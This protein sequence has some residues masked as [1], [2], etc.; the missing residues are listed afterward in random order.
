MSF[1]LFCRFRGQ[2]YLDEQLQGRRER[3]DLR[4]EHMDAMN[5]MNVR[6]TLNTRRISPR[7][8]SL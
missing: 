4:S 2:E 5:V 8:W 6:S 3:P 7:W 1:P